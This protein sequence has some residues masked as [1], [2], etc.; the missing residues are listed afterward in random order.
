MSKRLIVSKLMMLAVV[1]MNLPVPQ[2]QSLAGRSPEVKISSYRDDPFVAESFID[3]V[4][5]SRFGE[6]DIGRHLSGD[7]VSMI[8]ESAIFRKNQ[9]GIFVKFANNPWPQEFRSN[10]KGNFRFAD[11]VRFPLH[12]IERDANGQPVLKDGLQIWKPRDHRLGA[13]TT[14]AAGNAVIGAAEFWSGRH[15]GWG[16]DNADLMEIEAHSFIEFN[17]FFS[18]NTHT[19]HLGV[20]PYRRPG[21]TQIKMF[22]TATAWELAAHECGHAV[23]HAI[24]PN[25]GTA[26][27]WN[28]SFGDQIAMW[29]SL[30]D[31][32]RARN[33]LAETSGSLY[34]SNSVTRM[35]EAFAALTGR[36]TGVRDAFNDLKVSDTTPQIHERSTVLTGAAY[37]IFTLIYDDLKNGQGLGEHAA[38]SEAADIMGTFL[39]HGPDYM[40]E[41]MISLEDACKSYLKVDKEHYRGRFHDIFVDELIHRELFD[42]NSVDEWL[43]HEAAVPKLRLRPDASD[44]NVN[45]LIQANLDKLGIGPN[46]GLKLQNVTREHRFGKTIV[47]AH[48]TE[49][50]GDDA[51]LLDNHA[52]LTFRSDGTLADYHS[53]F[54]TD[55]TFSISTEFNVNAL[56][57]LNRAKRL[58]LHDHGG[59]LSLVRRPDGILSVETRIL[60]SQGFYCWLEV[61]SLEHP[62]GERR[63]VMVPT[64]PGDIAGIQPNGVE[65]LS[66]DDLGR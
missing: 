19:V 10:E 21:E 4:D 1:L 58:R 24:K 62:E 28:E 61:F 41:E 51:P 27:P 35:T 13:T 20:V 29:A 59:L 6:D 9:E 37:K 44:R 16:P 46:F 49:G 48:L 53:P 50:R 15:I 23:H 26:H 7:R 17:G 5:A 45:K 11:E 36:G 12:E 40:P 32:Q 60:R 66:A 18:L 43:A 33:L 31:S 54:H 52:I 22:E 65:I 63:E 14:F 64:I 42:S 38:V 56:A 57:L 47:R 30:R 3:R 25:N 2:A 34:T 39:T 8:E 55:Q